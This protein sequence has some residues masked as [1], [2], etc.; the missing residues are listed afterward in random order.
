MGGMIPQIAFGRVMHHRIR[1]VHHGFS[2][3]VF[4]LRVP[5]SQWQK[6]AGRF[7]PMLEFRQLSPLHGG[8]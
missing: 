3:P 1:P 4:F 6:A 8:W 2:Y 7:V 5:L